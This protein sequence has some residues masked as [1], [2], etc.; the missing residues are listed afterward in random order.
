MLDRA[1]PAL[2]AALARESTAD[3]RTHVEAAEDAARIHALDADALAKVYAGVALPAGSGDPLTAKLEPPLK[4][5]A[6]AQAIAAESAPQRKAKL[7]Q[8]LL[9]E[10][11]NH[12]L[13]V[14]VARGL[15]GELKNLKQG[16]DTAFFAE[17]AVEIALA[18]G[19][20]ATAVSW[21]VFGSTQDR[22]GDRPGAASLVGARPGGAMA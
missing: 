3:A 2:V 7:M 5:A 4:R 11:R 14:P 9:Q 17:T 16:N 13:Y 15:V 12:T 21:A 1:E 22:A 18:G 10:A 20:Y 6:L 8:A 19:D